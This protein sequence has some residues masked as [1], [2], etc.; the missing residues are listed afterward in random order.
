M[1]EMDGLTWVTLSPTI[2]EE[3]ARSAL[4]EEGRCLEQLLEENE[5]EKGDGS[6]A[7]RLLGSVLIPNR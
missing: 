1:N 6:T 5:G 7:T 2:K 4:L 3:G